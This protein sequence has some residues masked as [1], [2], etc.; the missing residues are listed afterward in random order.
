[1]ALITIVTI[2]KNN[3][4]G[5]HRTISSVIAQETR[6]W[7]LIIVAAASV[8]GSLELSEEMAKK[9]SNVRVVKQN[10][11][12]I[13]SAM[14]EG[15]DQANGEFIWFMNSGDE[16]ASPNTLDLAL[17][18][19]MSSSVGVVIGGYQIS[20]TDSVK[21]Y[22]FQRRNLS[23]F[24]FSFSR[25]GGCHQAML[26][27][28]S[29]L[30]QLGGFD[31][32]YKFNSDFSLVLKVISAGRGMRV[33]EIYADIE[34]G[35]FADQNIFSVHGEK[36]EIIRIFFDSAWVNF[37]SSCWT[38]AAR[39]KILSRKHINKRKMPNRKP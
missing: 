39:M 12:G 16:F 22:S 34:P 23:P 26:F 21:K 36:L 14:N 11:F 27:K 9:Y 24:D 7:E 6:N 8:D 37:L 15:L 35:G 5:L 31:L 4:N 13:F 29:Y 2:V 28:T 38:L 30:K 3:I 17:K 20:L 33:S 32:K 25:R 1:M 18:E 10:S 19:I